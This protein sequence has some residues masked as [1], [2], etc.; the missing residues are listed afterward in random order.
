MWLK[1]IPFSWLPSFFSVLDD[2]ENDICTDKGLAREIQTLAGI[3]VHHSSIYFFILFQTYNVMYKR[4]PL[5]SAIMQSSHFCWFRDCKN[6]KCLKRFMMNFDIPLKKSQTLYDVYSKYVQKQMFNYLL[7]NV[8]AKSVKCTAYCSIL[9]A[10]SNE[11][12]SFHQSDDED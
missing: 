11:M 3:T 2:F 10:D 12:L 5:N 9:M 8:S 6:S 4:H 1:G 7:I